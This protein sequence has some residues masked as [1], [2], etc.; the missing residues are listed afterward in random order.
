[1]PSKHIEKLTD[2]RF[3][4]LSH[5]GRRLTRPTT[6][7]HAAA[8]ERAVKWSEGHR[9]HKAV[10][11]AFTRSF[12]HLMA[13]HQHAGAFSESMKDAADGD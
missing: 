12:D 10:F 2:G 4:L 9:D 1:M 13:H 6:E 11:A 5:E 7:A 8:V 3:V